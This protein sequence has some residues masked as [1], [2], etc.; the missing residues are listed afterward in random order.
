MSCREL[1]RLIGTA[2]VEPRFREVLLG[3]RREEALGAFDLTPEE[4]AVLLSIQA[5]TLQ[6]FA[7]ALY[8]WM[9]A[10]NGALPFPVGTVERYL[11]EREVL[12]A[13]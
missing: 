7:Q 10:R 5:P 3:D 4:K 1:N 8:H 12:G 9:S 13:L 6:G 2:M 11:R